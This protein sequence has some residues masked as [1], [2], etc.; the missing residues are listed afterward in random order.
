MSDYPTDEDL[1]R[2]QTWA[3]DA[4]DSFE[5]FMAYVKSIGTYWPSEVFGWV[6]GSRTYHV[7]TGGWSGN[8]EILEA[9]R[10][11]YLFWAVCWREHR[12]G[13]HYIFTLP[14]P[15]SFTKGKP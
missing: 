4:H 1:E 5:Q 9:M 2:I 10:R 6:V 15:G 14:D 7:S 12:R 3:F 11:N 8:E 13:G